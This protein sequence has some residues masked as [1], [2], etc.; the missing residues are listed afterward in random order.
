[1]AEPK[2]LNRERG[3]KD[4]ASVSSS[5]IANAHNEQYA[6]YIREKATYW[7]NTAPIGAAALTVTMLQQEYLHWI[8]H[9]GELMHY[10]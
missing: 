9:W 1:M 7:K 6:F 5:F 10:S 3:T 4:N 8:R 2:I